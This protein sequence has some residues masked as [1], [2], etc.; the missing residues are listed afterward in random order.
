[1]LFS[2]NSNVVGKTKHNVIT[3]GYQPPT[4]NILA[5]NSVYTTVEVGNFIPPNYTKIRL[6]PQRNPIKHYR[7]K[8]NST[9]TNNN[10]DI[11]RINMPGKNI[12]KNIDSTNDCKICK[13]NNN[14][15]T[16]I[17]Q[18]IT[19]NNEIC[20]KTF[21]FQ[22]NNPNIWRNIGCNVQNNITRPAQTN[23]SSNYSS[24]MSNLMERRGISYKNNLCNN[25]QKII[26]NSSQCNNLSD[27]EFTTNK[28]KSISTTTSI[29][30]YRRQYYQNYTDGGA[31]ILNNYICC[32]N[33][34][35]N[36]NNYNNCNPY[37][38]TNIKERKTIC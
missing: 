22:D 33:V 24:S 10:S 1:M 16:F 2:F 6:A 34:L 11:N 12:I 21:S 8:Y 14:D 20:S 29:S 36:N 9:T 37:N 17:K 18:I 31:N 7:R 30:S 4:K 23:M 27:T 15:T 13:S 25:N 19:P 38:Y 35:N 5:N 28:N 26:K 3:A 32:N